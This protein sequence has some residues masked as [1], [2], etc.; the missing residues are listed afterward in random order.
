[1]KREKREEKRV[2]DGLVPDLKQRIRCKESLTSS[3]KVLEV[4]GSASAK[5]LHRPQPV[6]KIRRLD[7][8]EPSHRKGQDKN[9]RRRRFWA[10]GGNTWIVERAETHTRGGDLLTS[11]SHQ[12]IENEKQSVRTPD[13]DASV[14]SDLLL[15]STSSTRQHVELREAIPFKCPHSHL[16]NTNKS[17]R[18]S[19][20]EHHRHFCKCKK[21]SE[22][23]YKQF[24]SA[25]N[26]AQGSQRGRPL[27][28]GE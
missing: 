7:L 3:S 17:I 13:A 22:Q 11:S 16:P 10:R 28:E 19:I 9:E 20:L 15:L 4:L 23:M 6:K 26:K 1:M 27:P 2:G 14:M 24:K 12:H 5:T 18:K 21:I 8:E 25:C